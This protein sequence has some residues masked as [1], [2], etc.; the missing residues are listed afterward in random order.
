MVVLSRNNEKRS[1]GIANVFARFDIVLVAPAR[2]EKTLAARL[3]GGTT[4]DFA[5]SRA[6]SEPQPAPNSSLP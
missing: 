3:K 4:L 2:R 5:G 6:S 1:R